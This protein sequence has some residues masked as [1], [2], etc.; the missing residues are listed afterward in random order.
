LAKKI[1]DHLISPTVSKFNWI[2]KKCFYSSEL[3]HA[4]LE[5]INNKIGTSPEQ[6]NAFAQQ[7]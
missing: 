6:E 1:E 5:G 7:N 2:Q 4:T 3:N